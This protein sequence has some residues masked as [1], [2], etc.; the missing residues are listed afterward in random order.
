MKTHKRSWLDANITS[1]IFFAPAVLI[2]IWRQ[3]LLEL[4]LLQGAVTYLS[5]RNHRNF[6]RPCTLAVIEGISAKCLF[7][8]G[9]LQTL[10]SPDPASFNFHSACATFTAALFLLTN[11]RPR[12]W[13]PWHWIG[14]HLIPGIWSAS[15]AL[16]HSPI[17]L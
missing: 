3:T 2:C 7:L 4:A 8:Y 10:R 9:L 12:L 15:V 17:I 5:V 16:T 6:E 11:F 13:D 1:H 14:L